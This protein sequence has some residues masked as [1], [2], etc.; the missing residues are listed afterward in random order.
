MSTMPVAQHDGNF[1]SLS[2]RRRVALLIH[3]AL[4][5]DKA[6]KAWCKIVSDETETFLDANS[7]TTNGLSLQVRDG[8]SQNLGAPLFLRGNCAVHEL[9]KLQQ[10]HEDDAGLNT[11]M[12]RL[13]VPQVSAGS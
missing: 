12:A 7:T 3:E 6:V 13:H 2:N 8:E 5:R 4:H 11:S 10:R 9:E 1:C